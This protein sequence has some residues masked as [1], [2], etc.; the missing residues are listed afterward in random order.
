MNFDGKLFKHCILLISIGT[1]NSFR[2]LYIINGKIRDLLTYFAL[3]YVSRGS[4]DE[5]TESTLTQ[6]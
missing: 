3:N 4:V 6:H 1:N 2:V 5:R